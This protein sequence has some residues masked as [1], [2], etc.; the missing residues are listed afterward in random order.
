MAR[1][2][3]AADD[4]CHLLGRHA[5]G[6]IVKR[7]LAAIALGMMAVLLT[8]PGPAL[9]NPGD[10]PVNE[11]APTGFVIPETVDV[12]E[13]ASYDRVF[14]DKVKQAGLW[15]I[16]AASGPRRGAPASRRASSAN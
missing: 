16:P 1:A 7:V 2:G 12:Q 9:A 13:F 8:G 10:D 14:L 11:P 6:G 4:H 15:E 5:G 3:R